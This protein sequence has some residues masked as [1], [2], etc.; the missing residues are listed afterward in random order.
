KDGNHPNV[1]MNLACGCVDAALAKNIFHRKKRG[2]GR[3][4]REFS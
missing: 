1:R 4:V 3:A 2:K